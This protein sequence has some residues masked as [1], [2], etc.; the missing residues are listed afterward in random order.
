M[1]A[2]IEAKCALFESA[3]LLEA[4]GHVMHCDLN[5][6]PIFRILLELEAVEESLRFL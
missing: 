5:Q 6:K 2:G 3:H 4:Q 1:E